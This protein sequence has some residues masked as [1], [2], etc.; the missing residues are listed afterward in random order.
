MRQ[1]GSGAK[2]NEA[3]ATMMTM[4]AI[5]TDPPKI[6]SIGTTVMMMTAAASTSHHGGAPSPAVAPQTVVT[7]SP[8]ADAADLHVIVANG[9]TET[10][11]VIEMT[12]RVIGMTDH[13]IGMTRGAVVGRRHRTVPRS[14]TSDQ[15][16]RSR[17]TEMIKG[18]MMTRVD[19]GATVAALPRDPTTQA[20]TATTRT[21]IQA[22]S[23]HLCR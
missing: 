10:V 1:T 4:I 21:R 13:V 18:V 14:E 15:G 3:S 2:S 9:R 8:I 7:R 19:P 11:G 6:I 22:A 20:T 23:P 16:M 5:A 17:V 12:S